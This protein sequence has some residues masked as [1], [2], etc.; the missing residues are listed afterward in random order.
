MNSIRRW[1]LAAGLAIAS[2]LSACGGSDTEPEPVVP[3]TTSAV[4]GTVRDAAGNGL[5]GV[6]V[7]VAGKTA[8]T[9]A[10][11][12][13][14]V[15]LDKTT[16][17]TAV[18]FSKSGYASQVRAVRSLNTLASQA[19]DA[20][21]S[22][23]T[24]TSS[25]NPAASTTLTVA[26]SPAQVALG[27][28]V[29]VRGNGA[30]AN[31][32]ASVQITVL[33]AS[34]ITGVMPGELQAGSA[35]APQPIESFGALQVEFADADGSK[36]QLASGKTATI[37][38]PAV[39]RGGAALP[40][41]IPLYYLDEA[42]GLWVQ[43]GSATLAGS[44]PSQYYEGT[45]THFTAWNADQAYDTVYINGCLQDA[46]GTRITSSAFIFGEG[47]DYIGKSVAFPDAS[48]NF[49]LAVKKNS[50]TRVFGQQWSILR[51][52]LTGTSGEGVS[53]RM[54]S[55]MPSTIR[56]SAPLDVT[57]G[58]TDVT[59]SACLVLD[60]DGIAPP[61]GFPPVPDTPTPVAAYA[62]HYVGT[63]GGTE[64]GTFDVTITDTGR[65]L[66][67]G[68]S[69]T[70]NLDFIV[71]GTVA[72][73]GA[74]SLDAASG[75]AGAS[76]FSGSINSSTGALTGIWRYTSTPAGSTN[77]TFTGNRI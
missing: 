65:V 49:R 14:S 58:G 54:T 25:F 50:T 47:V 4:H 70:F 18:R 68:H 7:T 40:A 38:I 20:T 3:S 26:G 62:G 73:G 37:R 30:A 27:A 42:T 29:L 57:V 55:A 9:D 32:P 5:A 74:L 34:Q 72:P 64:S 75:T 10:S 24:A 51:S 15:D 23:V 77:G 48:G 1:S 53:R 11:G 33:D 69:A 16:P 59:L 43:D 41:T 28:N 61:L 66:G 76:L 63:F 12:T 36:L 39:S 52:A 22:S 71:N 44:A 21:M 2:F 60:K 19:V 56:Y 13:Y 67:S 46:G 17:D 8:D 35:A 6:H 31:G 45:V